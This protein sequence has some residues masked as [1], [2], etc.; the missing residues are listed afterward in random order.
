MPAGAL[1][2]VPRS[3]DF[4]SRA[5]VTARDHSGVCSPSEQCPA[6]VFWHWRA[7]SCSNVLPAYSP[8]SGA[9]RN[10]RCLLILSVTSRCQRRVPR[11]SGTVPFLRLQPAIS[12]ISNRE[13]IPRKR[14]RLCHPAGRAAVS[15]LAAV[16]FR[17]CPL[18]P[19]CGH[20]GPT[21]S[22]LMRFIRPLQAVS[23]LAALAACR[24]TPTTLSPCWRAADLQHGERFRGTVLIFAGYHQR[25]MIFPAACDGGVTA[26][27]PEDV[28]LPGYR[29][30]DFSVPTERLFYEAHVDGEVSGTA[31]G[32]PKV[33]LEHVSDPRQ[34]VP[35]WL[36]RYVR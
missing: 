5:G 11:T 16:R 12:G 34:M 22:P 31:F 35:Q 25:P 6:H 30:A 18:S 24:S 29:G 19:N 4:G 33:R 8:S 36:R 21:Y 26:E 28:V 13:H 7:A 14:H 3:R 10:R 20:S 23:A 15:R 27:L 2:T 32:R 17:E 9:A 1:H